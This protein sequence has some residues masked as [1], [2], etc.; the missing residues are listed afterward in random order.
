MQAFKKFLMVT[1][2][3]ALF[4]AGLWL[5]WK[6]GHLNTG[7]RQEDTV[8]VV[9]QIQT[10]SDLIT[11]KYVVEKVIILESPPQSTVG[12]FV[13]GNNRILLLAH[14]IVK[15]GIDLKRLKPGDIQVTG[16]TIRIH[17]PPP[18]V[19][20]AYLDEHRTKVIDSQRGF[21]RDYD[22]DLET[23]ARQNAVDDIS[24]AARTD[25]II[26]EAGNRAQLELAMFLMKAGF[27]HVEFTDRF[28]ADNPPLERVP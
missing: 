13:Q 19:T 22:K 3:I 6:A 24:R 11:V 8:A 17:L 14:G 15:A 10:L 28:P 5:G 9:R 18:Q 2:V 16:K 27:E 26:N 20:D 1:G 12:Q 25:G 7:L 21:L 4:V 23:T